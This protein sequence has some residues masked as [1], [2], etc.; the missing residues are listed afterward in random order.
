MAYERKEPLPPKE[1]RFENFYIRYGI[2]GDE[3]DAIAIQAEVWE[4]NNWA[5]QTPVFYGGFGAHPAQSD[6]T[7]VKPLLSL[8]VGWDGCSHLRMAYLH[9]DGLNQ[10]A[11]FVRLV[12]YIYRDV[13][14]R[15]GMTG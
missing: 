6:P 3:G 15:E 10:F 9:F 1:D 5:D 11:A 2:L 4:V 8:G 13:G 7:K 14:D 12:R